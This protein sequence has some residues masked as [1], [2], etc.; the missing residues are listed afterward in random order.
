MDIAIV[1]HHPSDIEIGLRRRPSAIYMFTPD[2]IAAL[3]VPGNR[4]VVEADARLRMVERE[5]LVAEHGC[6]SSGTYPARR[7]RGPERRA[8]WFSDRELVVGL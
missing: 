2:Q 7:L 8:T 4:E 5:G 3:I 1:A 6:G